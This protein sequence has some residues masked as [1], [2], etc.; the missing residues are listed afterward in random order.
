MLHIVKTL[1]KIK[2]VLDYLGDDDHVLLVEDSVYIANPNHYLHQVLCDHTRISILENDCI[3]RGLQSVVSER[4]RKVD[5]KG[6]VELTVL[7]NK[8][9]TW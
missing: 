4:I 2:L 1:D 7:H 3:A 9:I 6:F 8:S 5:F